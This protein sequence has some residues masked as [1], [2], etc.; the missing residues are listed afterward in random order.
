METKTQTKGQIG[1]WRRVTGV[2]L[3]FLTAE[4]MLLSGF[5]FYTID[6]RIIWAGG[7]LSAIM[8]IAG[9]A[10]DVTEIIKMK[11]D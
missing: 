10:K 8:L 3:G 6:Y 9:L 11:L 5:E 1:L 7:T 2:C 4:S